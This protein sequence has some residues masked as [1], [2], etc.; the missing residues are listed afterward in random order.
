MG[1]PNWAPGW[2]GGGDAFVDDEF[3]D[4]DVEGFAEFF[5]GEFPLRGP[6]VFVAA[7]EEVV[8]DVLGLPEVDVEGHGA[9]AGG[10]AE[11]GAERGHHGLVGDR[12]S[13]VSRK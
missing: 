2:L 5:E 13:V 8:P 3:V 1:H 6:V 12:K 11:R 10:D 4:A 7:E 9:E